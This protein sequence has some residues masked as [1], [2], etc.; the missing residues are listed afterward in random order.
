MSTSPDALR[1]LHSSTQR[2]DDLLRP[3]GDEQIVAPAYPSEWT[4]A[5]VVS[6][7]G[8][9]AVL[10][11]RR[12]AD[13]LAGS[14]TPQ[15]FDRAVWDEWDAKSPRAKVVDGLS[16]IGSLTARLEALPEPE[17]AR[18]RTRMGPLELD[19][20][21][22]V[23]LRLNEQLLHE[24]DVAVALDPAAALAPDGTA[25]VVDNLELIARFAGRAAG[26]ERTVTIR[27]L[28]P[29]RTFDV[30]LSSDGVAIA[31]AGPGAEPELTMPAES[32]IR[33]VYGRLDPEHTP[34]EVTGDDAVLEA[35]RASFLGV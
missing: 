4:V 34:A 10:L 31:T 2:L 7:L 15:G 32:L 6:H 14:D 26:E 28:S 25:L 1:A 35:L 22:L 24:W 17:R 27:T 9:S 3:L 30:D 12:V 29:E 13:G 21:A 33:L 20:T 11:E 5:D 16:A 18:L 8:S 23:G 19:W